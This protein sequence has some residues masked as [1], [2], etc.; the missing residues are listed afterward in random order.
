MSDKK[1]DKSE[2]KELIELAIVNKLR[3]LSH[4]IGDKLY[5]REDST[6]PPSVTSIVKSVNEQIEKINSF[7]ESIKNAIMEEPKAIN[8]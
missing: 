6:Q 5:E 2:I 7:E 1:L 8:K 4:F 3:K